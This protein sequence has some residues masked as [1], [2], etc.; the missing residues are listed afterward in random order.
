MTADVISASGFQ[1]HYYPGLIFFGISLFTSL[2][3]IILFIIHFFLK[4]SINEDQKQKE[5]EHDTKKVL[6]NVSFAVFVVVV[7]LLFLTLAE[8]II[9]QQYIPSIIGISHE[10]TYVIDHLGFVNNYYPAESIIGCT[11]VLSI[12]GII[13]FASGFF[14]KKMA[15]ERKTQENI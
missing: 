13:I 5:M 9:F 4:R 8:L 14:K 12:I 7:V 1:I 10:S 2:A 15:T 11:L 3:G 6:F